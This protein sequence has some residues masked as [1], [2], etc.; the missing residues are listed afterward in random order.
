MIARDCNIHHHSDW[1]LL[2]RY[3]AIRTFAYLQTVSLILQ[4]FSSS[5]R[6][7]KTLG[8]ERS[9]RRSDQCCRLGTAHEIEYNDAA[10]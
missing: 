8:D 9:I 7:H 5:I 2:G 6:S 10:I 4:V 1:L 3:F